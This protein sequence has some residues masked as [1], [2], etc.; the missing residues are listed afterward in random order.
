MRWTATAPIFCSDVQILDIKLLGF[1]HRT[2]LKFEDNV[3]HSTFIFPD[4]MVRRRHS[5]RL[6]MSADLSLRNRGRRTPVASVL[7]ALWSKR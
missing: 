3:K 4:E 5:V 1:K 7:S 2:T 6:A